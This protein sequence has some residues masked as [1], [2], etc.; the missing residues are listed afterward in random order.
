[1]GVYGVAPYRF[2]STGPGGLIFGYASLSDRAITEGV[3]LLA[4]AVAE[5]RSAEA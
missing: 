2:T 5:L 4:D 1:V 3:D